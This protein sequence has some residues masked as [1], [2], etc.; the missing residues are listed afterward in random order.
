MLMS[1]AVIYCGSGYIFYRIWGCCYYYV[2][3]FRK[4]VCSS[5]ICGVF[6][7]YLETL[8]F[9]VIHVV[10]IIFCFHKRSRS[11]ECAVHMFY[12][13]ACMFSL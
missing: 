4:G 6:L 9:F 2:L 7:K 11:T 12:C 13:I 3:M 8:P 10:S 1:G 5:S